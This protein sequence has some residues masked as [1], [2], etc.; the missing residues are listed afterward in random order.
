[1]ATLADRLDHVLGRK[2]ADALHDAFGMTTVEDLLRHYPHRYAT[3]GASSARV[4]PRRASTSRSSRGSSR[5]RRC[6]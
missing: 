4:G 2:T 1:M 6:R 3:Q 5:R